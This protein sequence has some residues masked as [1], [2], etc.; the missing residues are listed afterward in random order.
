MKT[1]I[2]LLLVV[3]GVALG[4]Y[5]GLWLAF[6]GGIVQIIEAIKASPVEAMGIAIGIVKIVFAGFI[7]TVSAM[8]L[9]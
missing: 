3:C 6:I 4:L 9:V 2:G 1:A 7:G 5:C 8:L